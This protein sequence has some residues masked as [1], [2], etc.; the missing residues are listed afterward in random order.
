MTQN[1]EKRQQNQELQHLFFVLEKWI[2]ERIYWIKERVNYFFDLIPK[3]QRYFIVFLLK[4]LSKT[5]YYF[6]FLLFYDTF[7]LKNNNCSTLHNFKIHDNFSTK[8][9]YASH[10]GLSKNIF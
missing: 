9:F 3:K 5:V 7:L 6:G 8:T 2:K 10:G 4:K 1:K